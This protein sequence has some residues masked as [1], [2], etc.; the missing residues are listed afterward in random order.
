MTISGLFDLPR[1]M[2]PIEL[3]PAHEA[4]QYIQERES[5]LTAIDGAPVHLV[6]DGTS[7]TSHDLIAQ[8]EDHAQ[9]QGTLQGTLLFKL[10]EQAV[11]S[12]C[13]F[14]IWWA[15]DGPSLPVPTE[16]D[17]PGQAIRVLQDQIDAGSDLA[18]RYH[19]E[20]RTAHCG[21]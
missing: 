5:E 16:C 1:S 2:A 15:A 21:A 4:Q 9:K 11:A 12:G 6:H 19:P 14:R 13:A 17:S 10:I 8:A 7:G 18:V 3:I 20:T